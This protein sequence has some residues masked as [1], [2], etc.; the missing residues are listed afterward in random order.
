MKSILN[1][2]K[3]L[4][5]NLE[6]SRD[7]FYTFS[8]IKDSKI[9]QTLLMTKKSYFIQKFDLIVLHHL[10]SKFPRI[11][12]WML[13]S[14]RQSNFRFNFTNSY[15]PLLSRHLTKTVQYIL[16]FQASFA[17][18]FKVVSYLYKR[19]NQKINGCKLIYS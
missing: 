19:C 8:K 10:Y 1:I 6:E 5:G 2:R 15:S 17:M 12:I 9:F 4:N 13:F 7:S 14:F 11:W 16:L 3:H 18:A